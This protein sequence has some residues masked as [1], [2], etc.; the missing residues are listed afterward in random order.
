MSRK[1]NEYDL[2]RTSFT[3]YLTALVS[4]GKVLDILDCTKAF[5]L[6]VQSR[7]LTSLEAEFINGTVKKS[8]I[9]VSGCVCGQVK[10]SKIDVS[11]EFVMAV[12]GL[13]KLAAWDCGEIETTDFSSFDEPHAAQYARY[14]L[15][16]IL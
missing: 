7:N 9:D 8:K 2:L 4:T 15:S 5:D 6:A 3:K 14:V 13:N 1:K 10:M 12:E 11:G 16:I